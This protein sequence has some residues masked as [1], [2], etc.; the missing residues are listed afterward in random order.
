MSEAVQVIKKL[1]SEDWLDFEGMYYS[2]KKSNLYT[3][4]ETKV[5]LYIAALGRQSAE[6]TRAEGDGL[7]TNELDPSLIRERLFPAFEQGASKA[8]KDPSSMPKAVFVPASYDEDRQ[9]ALQ[10]IAYWRGSTIK[11]FFNV[12]YPDPRDIE[13]DGKVVG[14]DTFE[15]MALVISNAEEGWI[16]KLQKYVDLG[17]T[18]IV[19]IN[20]SPDKAKLIEMVAEQITPRSKKAQVGI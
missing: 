19:L 20:S 6:L 2:L 13:E 16:N 4:P 5:P 1:W 18:E 7:V 3:K 11:A 9:K 15:K 10:S 14:N 12:D 17:V 8:G